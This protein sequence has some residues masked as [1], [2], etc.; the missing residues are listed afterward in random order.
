MLFFQWLPGS[1]RPPQVIGDF[2]RDPLD[3]SASASASASGQRDAEVDGQLGEGR[4]RPE[5][6]AA[7]V[8]KRN[9]TLRLF[10]IVPELSGSYKCK[11][12]SFI[13]EDFKQMDMLVYCE[14]AV[15]NDDMSH[16]HLCTHWRIFYARL[17]NQLPCG[18]DASNES[19][20]QFIT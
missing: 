19:L 11:V 7:A 18:F 15:V 17:S 1:N 6:S 9:H 20:F 14:Y 8:T 4:G 10:N 5:R 2:F 3:P 16:P 12:S 13:D